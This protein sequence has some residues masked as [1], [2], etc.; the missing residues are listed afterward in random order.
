[1]DILGSFLLFLT[2]VAGVVG[3]VDLVI[4]IALWFID[5]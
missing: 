3:F 4:M 2:M 1:M 5:R